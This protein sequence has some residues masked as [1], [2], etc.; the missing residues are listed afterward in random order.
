MP[1]KRAVD[2]HSGLKE[3]WGRAVGRGDR[4]GAL[5][6]RQLWWKPRNVTLVTPG[7]AA[8]AS[9]RALDG[10]LTCTFS[11]S[12]PSVICAPRLRAILRRQNSSKPLAIPAELSRLGPNYHAHTK[13]ALKTTNFAGYSTSEG[14]YEVQE[15]HRFRKLFLETQSIY[16]CVDIGITYAHGRD[17]AGNERARDRDR[18]REQQ[19]T[20]AQAVAI[21]HARG[22]YREPRRG[23]GQQEIKHRTAGNEHAWG[24]GPSARVVAIEHT[25][26]G[27]RA[28]MERVSWALV[29][30]GRQVM[31]AWAADTSTWGAD[32]ERAGSGGG[33]RWVTSARAADSERVGGG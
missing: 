26:N 25:G 28:R 16:K 6:G 11:E 20:S 3:N 9:E 8:E 18:A 2:A 27:H 21:G 4:E 10:R 14:I 7:N 29:R 15:P 31:S 33:E 30:A 22:G 19:A 13:K 23:R 1:E 5:D 32:S 17:Q 12:W 24:G